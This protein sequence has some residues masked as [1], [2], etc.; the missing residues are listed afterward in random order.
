[1]SYAEFARALAR[2]WADRSVADGGL[3]ILRRPVSTHLLGRR[4]VEEYSQESAKPPAVDFLAWRQTAGMGREQRSWFSPPGG[5][6]ATLVRPLLPDFVL[7]TLPP[8]VATSLC[9]A[10]NVDL[11]GRC[12]L[13]WPNDLLVEGRKLGGILIDAFSRGDSGSLAVISF[14][15]N[16]RRVDLSAATSLEGET[17]GPVGLAELAARLVGAVDVALRQGAP[18]SEIVGRYRR[19]SLHRPG[20]MIRCRRG[21]DVVEGVFD[22]FDRHGF[23]RLLVGGEERLLTAGEVADHD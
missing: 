18:A 17:R 10:L 4:V 15:V 11:D 16:H 20:D 21:D 23:L 8:L 7:Q 22:G 5:L 6:Y 14:G 1:M 3:V 13:K 9:E 2:R 19:L 12:R